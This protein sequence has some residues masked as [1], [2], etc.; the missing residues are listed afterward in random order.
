M[1]L[2]FKLSLELFH[3]SSKLLEDVGSNFQ[4]FMRASNFQS[5]CVQTLKSKQQNVSG[6][7]KAAKATGNAKKP[8]NILTKEQCH[9]QAVPAKQDNCAEKKPTNI[10]APNK[11]QQPNSSANLEKVKEALAVLSITLNTVNQKKWN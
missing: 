9:K 8:E 7:K 5:M 10:S 11:M 4:T 3:D 2:G 1:G 6:K